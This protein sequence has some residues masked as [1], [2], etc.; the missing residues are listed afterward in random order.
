MGQ[1]CRHVLVLTQLAELVL[2]HLEVVEERGEWLLAKIA[3][4]SF[5]PFQCILED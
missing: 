2:T 4:F 3:F 5:S 1:L